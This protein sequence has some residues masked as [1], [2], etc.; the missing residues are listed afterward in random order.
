M[1]V[2]MTRTHR[3]DIQVRFGDTDAQGHL[4]NVAYAAYAEQARIDFFAEAGREVAELI[5]ARIAID[6]R[7]Q[8][9]FGEAVHVDTR[10][11]RIGTSSVTLVQQVVAAGEAA[12]EI[13]SVVVLFDYAEQHSRPLPD[14][15]KNALA[16]FVTA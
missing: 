15:V 10:V 5:L 8:V 11:L 4:N 9:R 7:R 13:E 14:S 2:V 6:F 1:L 12:A 3:T 16:A